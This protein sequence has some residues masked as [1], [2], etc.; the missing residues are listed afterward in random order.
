MN[1]CHVHP[2]T[3]LIDKIKQLNFYRMQSKPGLE[4]HSS[5]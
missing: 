2:S 4:I 3:L 1:V 5:N